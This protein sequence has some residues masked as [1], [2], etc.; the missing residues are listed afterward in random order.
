MTRDLA[1]GGVGFGLL[2]APVATTA[3]NW[4]GLERGGIAAALAT[5]MRM[6]GMMVGLSALTSYGLD[7]FAWL[8]RDLALPLPAPGETAAA[9]AQK[10]A[11]YAARVLQATTTVYHELFFAAAGLCLVALVPAALL[12]FPKQPGVK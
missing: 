3:I 5:L 1:A 12:R 11:E 2:L 6:I 9:V 8:V 4:A 10:Q 7:R